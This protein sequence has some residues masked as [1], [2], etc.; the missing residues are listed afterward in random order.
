MFKGP[1]YILLILHPGQIKPDPVERQIQGARWCC[2]T[3]PF[4]RHP[5]GERS[6]RSFILGFGSCLPWGKK[7]NEFLLHAQINSMANLVPCKAAGSVLTVQEHSALKKS[8]NFSFINSPGSGNC[9]LPALGL[10]KPHG[11]IA[12][13]FFPSSAMKLRV[14]LANKQ[15]LVPLRERRKEEN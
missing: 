4:V 13:N 2:D 8:A 9:F 14:S 15:S 3:L 12:W 5:D 6:R 7:R 10:Q 1:A 11:L